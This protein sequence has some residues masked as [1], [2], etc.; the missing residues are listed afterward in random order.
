MSYRKIFNKQVSFTIGNLGLE[1][2]TPKQRQLKILGF[3]K[4]FK[5]YHLEPQ[6]PELVWNELQA[7]CIPVWAAGG[8]IQ[9]K[10]R[11]LFIYRN[12][13]WDLPK[14]KHDKNETLMQTALRECQEECGLKGLKI[15]AQLPSTFHVYTQSKQVYLKTTLWF[16]M[17]YT[18]TNNGKPQRSEG[19]QKIAW[20][21][22]SQ[23]KKQSSF[24][25]PSIQELLNQSDL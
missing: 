5:S 15:T 25:F 17:N 4:G 13:S 6:N 9:R 16:K 2:L 14:G 8:L 11:F 12:D 10:D 24:L 20:L 1:S 3:L 7:H 18:G 21:N 22:R 23:I 19:I